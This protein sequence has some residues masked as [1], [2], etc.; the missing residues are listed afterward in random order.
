MSNEEHREL[1]RRD[2]ASNDEKDENEGS[3]VGTMTT[4]V[5][6]DVSTIASPADSTAPPT[7]STAPLPSPFAGALA[8]NFSD[9]KCPEF[10]NNLLSNQTFKA[11]YPISLLLQGSQSFFDAEKSRFD[12][13]HVLDVACAANVDTCTSYF[14]KLASNLTS[15]GNCGK[16][17][18]DG[19]AL[20]V[21]AYEGMQA[22]K[23]IYEATCLSDTDD[24][25]SNYCFTNAVTNATTP[26]NSY[27]YF[28]PLNSLLPATAAPSCSACTRQIMQIYQAA[29]ADRKAEIA[30]T[31][32][33]AATQIN[34]ECGNNFTNTSLAAVVPSDATMSVYAASSP[35]PF[36]FS[37]ALMTISHWIL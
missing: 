2:A 32:Q 35:W 27:L 36:I 6:I 33:S 25:S 9:Q 3:A 11:C 24:P 22:Y 37:L 4:E 13:T 10:I 34:A 21:Q 15:D 1:R 5:V 19:N 29:T 17:Y 28:L 20:V 12:I 18:K 31:Y 30:N 16:D 7:A 8:A 14:S 26:S 23:T